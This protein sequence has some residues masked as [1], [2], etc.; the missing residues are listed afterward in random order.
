MGVTVEQRGGGNGLLPVLVDQGLPDLR[1]ALDQAGRSLPGFVWRSLE[2]LVDCGDVE[3]GF[4][5]LVC[6]GCPHHRLVPFSCKGRGICPRC[7][8]RRMSDLAARW[9]DEVLPHVPVRQ[10]V[11]TVP[12]HRRWLLSRNPDLAKGVLG[13]ALRVLFRFYGDRAR[14]LGV[15]GRTGSITVAQRFGS[16]LNLNLHFHSLLLD[17]V[18]DADGVFHRLPPPTTDEVGALVDVI[19]FRVERWLCRK[20]Y[21]PEEPDEQ[22]PDDALALVQAASL[23]GRTNLGRRKVRRVQTHGGREYAMPP[24]CAGCDGFTLHGGTAV[25]EH[26]REGLE[27]LCRYVARPA[28]GAGRLQQRPD[29]TVRLELKTPWADGTTA[30]L[31]TPAELTERLAALV[32]PPRAHTVHYHGVLGSRSRL[33]ERIAPKPPPPPPE[34]RLRLTRT[35]APVPAKWRS[36]AELLSRVFTQ[37]GF[38]CPR[39]NEPMS[40]R[41][42]VWPPAAGVVVSALK[43]SARGPPNAASAAAP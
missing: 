42:I 32:P 30:I 12:W 4:A 7:G 5:W 19:A 23:A 37:D 27:R 20:G 39:C 16:S 43:R 21:G 24:R 26:D 35:P 40:L 25:G 41:A 1:H 11:L 28:L 22:D 29:G 13:I 10:W 31:L 33:R 3:N 2:R 15:V 34:A 17:G 18:Y 6:E 14:E 9:V 38:R 8:G 36:W